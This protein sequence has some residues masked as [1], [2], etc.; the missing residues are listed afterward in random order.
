M[1]IKK[2]RTVRIKEKKIVLAIKKKLMESKNKLG[3]DVISYLTKTLKVGWWWW[4]M[5]TTL[6]MTRMPVKLQKESPAGCTG[7]G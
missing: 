2:N 1:N 3:F 7:E 5:L 4:S 6:K